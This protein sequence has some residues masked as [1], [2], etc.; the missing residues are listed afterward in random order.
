MKETETITPA[1]PEPHSQQPATAETPASS[2]IDPVPAPDPDA[3]PPVNPAQGL[4]TF[5]LLRSPSADNTPVTAPD[6]DVTAFILSR[7]RRSAWDATL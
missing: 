3:T 2:E 5:E 7:R 1:A 4:G 6:D